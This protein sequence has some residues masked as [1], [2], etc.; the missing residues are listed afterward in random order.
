MEICTTVA[1]GFPCRA[2]LISYS[3]YRCNRRGHPDNWLPDDPEEIEF[4]LLPLGSDKPADW[5]LQAAS[6]ADLTRIEGEL[7]AAMETERAEAW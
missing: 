5:L 1:G 3:A 6:E 7:V 4:E 2:R